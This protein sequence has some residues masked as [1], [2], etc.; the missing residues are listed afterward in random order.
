MDVCL[1]LHQREGAIMKQAI[2]TA[3]LAT[4]LTTG[5]AGRC[6]ADIIY[7][8]LLSSTYTPS[9][10][11][12]V[13]GAGR[14]FGPATHAET[15]VAAASGTEGDIQVAMWWT[16]SGGT[17][18]ADF[19]LTL[20]NSSNTVLDV[21]HGTAPN[22]SLGGTLSVIKIVSTV[23]PLLTAGQT[24]TLTASP[25]SSNTFDTWDDQN[26]TNPSFTSGFLV[27]TTSVPEPSSLTMISLLAAGA[28]VTRCLRNRGGKRTEA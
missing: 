24:Y 26:S 1:R 17:S 23:N 2:W 18:T 19:T 10:G 22:G 21:L 3:V 25:G 12:S 28:G 7:N 5:V 9:S 6:Q 16:P 4:M 11:F 20:R 13:L 8:T 14:A 15:F 27:E